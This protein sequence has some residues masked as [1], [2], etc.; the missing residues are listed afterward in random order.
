MF[1][2]YKIGGEKLAVLLLLPEGAALGPGPGEGQFYLRA[3]DPWR[4]EGLTLLTFSVC[5]TC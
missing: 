5:V 4:R 1:L 3:R 2:F